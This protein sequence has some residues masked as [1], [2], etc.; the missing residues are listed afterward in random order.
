LEAEKEKM[1]WTAYVQ[2]GVRESGGMRS[3]FDFRFA[4]FDWGKA[5]G[6]KGA[7]ARDDGKTGRRESLD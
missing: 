2:P 6:A 5:A 7:S 3:I 4:I 1:T